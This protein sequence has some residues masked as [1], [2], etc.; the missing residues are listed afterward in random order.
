MV[1]VLFSFGQASGSLLFGHDSG[2]L[3]FGQALFPLFL[4]KSTFVL[5]YI[6]F[7]IFENLDTLKNC[8]Y[9]RNSF[10]AKKVVTNN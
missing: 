10:S 6:L 8:Q 5:N 4:A 3:L 9:V 2:F 1:L 7:S